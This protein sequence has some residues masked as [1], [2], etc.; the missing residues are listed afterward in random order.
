MIGR[1]SSW[2]GGSLTSFLC[3]FSSYLH[4]QIAFMFLN[5]D[6]L[7]IYRN[8]WQSCLIW[9]FLFF[10]LLDLIGFERCECS[11]VCFP[12]SLEHFILQRPCFLY[13]SLLIPPDPSSDFSFHVPLQFWDAHGSCRLSFWFSFL[14]NLK[15][16]FMKVV[17]TC[18]SAWSLTVVTLVDTLEK[19][20]FTIVTLS[21]V[22]MEILFVRSWVTNDHGWIFFFFFGCFMFC[23]D[24]N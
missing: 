13:S 11:V 24:V 16:R 20:Y 3:R 19:S 10:S 9:L 23:A 14:L 7:Y 8:T 22:E 17:P 1:Q 12:V 4:K 6:I 5:W 21:W 2:V 15:L 18:S